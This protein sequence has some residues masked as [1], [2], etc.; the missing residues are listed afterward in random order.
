MCTNCLMESFL[1]GSIYGDDLLYGRR[2]RGY[3]GFGDSDEI[4]RDSFAPVS[5]RAMNALDN[6]CDL[7]PIFLNKKKL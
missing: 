6:V 3:S 2:S 7:M 5:Q 4:N 1:G